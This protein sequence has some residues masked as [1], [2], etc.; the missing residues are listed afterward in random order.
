M[1][2][3]YDPKQTEEKIYQLWLKSGYFNPDKIKTKKNYTILLP[4]PN[5]T[6]SLHMGHALN[7]TII[8]ILIRF[9]RMQGFS[10]A[11][12]PGTDHAG[13]ATQNAVEKELRKN[14]TSRFDLGREKFIEAVWQW[15]EKYG[16]I[17]LDQLKKIGLSADWSRI[18]FTMD[19]EYS[20]TVKKTFIHY[21]EKGLI[22]RG[23]RVIN[24]CTRCQTSLSDL[25]IEHQEE[26][27]Y[28]W[29]IKYPLKNPTEKNE[30]IIV[31]T[32]R[33]ET[34][35][36]DAAVAVNPQDKKYQNLI[37]QK[38]ILPIQNKEIPIIADKAIDTDFGT[39]AVKV[40]P[41]HDLLDA[42]IA[43][44]HNLPFYK[45]ID[46][47]GRM[48]KLAGP[49]FEGLK[50][51]E[52]REKIIEKLKNK[53][54]IEKIEDY[55]HNVARC[56]RCQTKIEPIPSK[57]WFLKMADLAKIAEKTVRSKKN[58][59]IPQ[60]FEKTY[61]AWL[62]NIKDWCISRQ[63]WWGH[64]LPVFF[65]ENEKEKFAVALDKPRICPFCKNCQMKQ[66]EEVLD[67]WFSSALWPFAEFPLKDLKK[68]YP[69][70]VL[71]TARDIINLWVGRMIFSGLE[72][73]KQEP[74]VK[75]F[76]HPTILN[77]EGKRMSKSLGTGVDPLILIENFGADA[78]RFGI[79]W[80]TMG[81]QDIRWDETAV[82]AGKKF[83][84]KI[85]NASRFVLENKPSL[86]YADFNGLMRMKNLTTA[87]KKILK[88]LEIAQKSAANDIE[89]FRFGHALRATHD[90]FWHQFCD[91]YI[92]K[93]KSQITDPKTE[94]TTKTILL[95][96]L[97]SSLKMLHPFMPFITEEIYQKLPSKKEKLL[98]IS[99]RS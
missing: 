56:Y 84:N 19:P 46:E 15:K 2:K 30:F 53:N 39:G 74:F 57:Q 98:M 35:L 72:F 77:K 4:P 37:G 28:L 38:V 51:L 63:I 8:D 36:G 65:C 23:E 12:L 34:L 25:E 40:T 45:I 31:A 11:C 88:Q 85:W 14:G 97:S 80:Q 69:S 48:T 71:V 43:Q 7:A 94:K 54:L 22:Y 42:E 96:V 70:A 49:E 60:K 50:T 91:V 59:I 78:T 26:K 81:G 13:I 66:S 67:T 99:N 24:W 29:H 33:P 32:T 27:S 41:A 93:S 16:N 92:E 83:C 10:A 44:R 47:K 61:F 86:I 95:F 5:I 79:I 58:Q 18:R 87:D 75:T 62:K 17:I 73:L 21:H 89:K 52:A 20:E 9:K 68:F 90:F 82:L 55:N 1:E 6:G 3:T 64:Q 76:I